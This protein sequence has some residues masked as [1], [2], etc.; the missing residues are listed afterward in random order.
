MDT[1]IGKC[2][3]CKAKTI[4][5]GILANDDYNNCEDSI[6]LVEICTNDQNHN[7]LLETVYLHGI[8]NNMPSIDDDYTSYDEEEEY[9][10]YIKWHEK[11]SYTITG[12]G[13]GGTHGYHWEENRALTNRERARIQ[14]FPDDFIFE[15]SKEQVR[16]QI[17]MAVPPLLA[18]IVFTAVLKTFAG[19][20]YPHVSAS[21]FD[22]QPGLL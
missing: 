21:H 22:D 9:E 6:R 12:S 7:K 4:V 8:T 16:K 10:E 5:L 17:G 13:G 14:T 15:G 19:V 20:P 2:E 11:P 18:R 3:R 1:K